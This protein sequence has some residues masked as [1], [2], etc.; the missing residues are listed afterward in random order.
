MAG[1]KRTNVPCIVKTTHFPVNL[2]EDMERILY[3]TSDGKKKKYPSMTNLI[4]V[5]VK[6]LIKRERRVIEENGVAWDH[7]TPSY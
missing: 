2:V 1:R 6:E 3:L 4:I 5:A 7:I